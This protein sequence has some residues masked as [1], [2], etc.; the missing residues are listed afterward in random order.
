MG[1]EGGEVGGG[2]C[3]RSVGWGKRR[4]RGRGR[5][6]ANELVPQDAVGAEGAEE[7]AESPLELL[8]RRGVQTFQAAVDAREVLLFAVSVGSSELRVA[9]RTLWIA[10][11]P[12][13]MSERSI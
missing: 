6:V 7:A 11:S 9:R 13:F 5:A 12:L 4:R 10:R 3:L 8:V 2:A 1:E